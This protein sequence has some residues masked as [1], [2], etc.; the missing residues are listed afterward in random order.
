MIRKAFC[1]GAFLVSAYS[2]AMTVTADTFGIYADGTIDGVGLVTS[3]TDAEDSYSSMAAELGYAYA[4]AS[5][6]GEYSVEAELAW[7]AEQ[8]LVSQ[9]SL[10]D[11]VVNDSSSSQ[12]A[13]LTLDI[14]ESSASVIGY[15]GEDASGWSDSYFSLEVYLDDSVIWSTS[16]FVDS[17]LSTYLSGDDL[18]VGEVEEDYDSDGW[19]YTYS[20]VWEDQEVEIDLG[21]FYS[22]QSSTIEIVATA[23]VSTSDWDDWGAMVG[24]TDP[25]SIDFTS[26]ITFAS[27]SVTSASVPEPA[28]FGLMSLGLFGLF[29]SRKRKSV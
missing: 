17:S 23:I 29:A 7:A 10:S 13:T 11:Q 24:F 12:D 27:N 18:L 21:E 4:Y 5:D 28:T 2:N 20:Y 1:I 16:V 19:A 22:G 8:T 15:G 25:M 6:S 26:D 3:S 14:Y 9:V